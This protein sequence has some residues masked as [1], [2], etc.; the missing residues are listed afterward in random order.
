MSSIISDNDPKQAN[1]AF[2]VLAPV[3]NN[4]LSKMQIFYYGFRFKE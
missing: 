4:P 2:F 1:P 3:E